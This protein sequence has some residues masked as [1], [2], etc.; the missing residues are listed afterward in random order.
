MQTFDGNKLGPFKV[1]AKVG[2]ISYK[3]L[4]PDSFRLHQVFHCD[5]LSH[6]TTSTSLRPHQAEIE[7]DIE[8]YAINFIDD[9]KM[10]TWPRR[11]LTSSNF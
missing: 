1:M 6:P 8:E 2:I 3:L 4:L 7:G 5:I 9:V 11:V 10:Y